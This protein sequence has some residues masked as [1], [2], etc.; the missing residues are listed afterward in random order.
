M[1]KDSPQA[2][3]SLPT[4]QRLRTSNAATGRMRETPASAHHQTISASIPGQPVS[5]VGCLIPTAWEERRGASGE[6]IGVLRFSGKGE[7]TSAAS[8]RLVTTT[9]IL[10]S[11]TI[12]SRFYWE[13]L[14][15]HQQLLTLWA[16]PT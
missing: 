5:L 7:I 15:S 16:T 6:W 1:C 9:Q 14:L 12:L 3:R 11:T 4:I 8:G 10:R 13:S 2:I